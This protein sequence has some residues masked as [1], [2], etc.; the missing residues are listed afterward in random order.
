MNSPNPLGVLVLSILPGVAWRFWGMFYTM[1][2]ITGHNLNEVHLCF[3]EEV[4]VWLWSDSL[5]F[6]LYEDKCWSLPSISSARVGRN[7]WI[8][9]YSWHQKK[10]YTYVKAHI[11][12]ELLHRLTCV[13]IQYIEVWACD[14][15]LYASETTFHL[16]LFSFEYSA[17]L[18][19]ILSFGADCTSNI[20]SHS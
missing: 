3:S 5:I 18:K 12:R 4:T 11:M 16:A 17:R 20:L 2:H 1:V 15:K 10:V 9:D 13:S 14:Q 6:V 8:Y 7:P 19:C